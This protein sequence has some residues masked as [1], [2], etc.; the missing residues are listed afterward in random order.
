MPM[1]MKPTP[2]KFC[3][4]CGL[5]LERRPLKNKGRELEALLHFSRRKFCSRVCMAAGFRG[6]WRPVV[7]SQEGRYRA[8]TII[9]KVSCADCGKRVRLD[10]HHINENPLDNSRE[11]LGVLCRS[12]HS[13]RHRPARLCDVL[14]C[15]RKHK[16]HGLCDMHS[17]RRDRGAPVNP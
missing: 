10:V 14:G 6:R 12:C 3:M 7:Q 8:R 9:Q 2:L 11:N 1:P 17:Q 15:G 4:S 13:K 5:K 16:G